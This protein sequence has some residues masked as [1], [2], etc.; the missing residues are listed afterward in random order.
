MAIIHTTSQ[1]LPK[2][3][4]AS[5]ISAKKGVSGTAQQKANMKKTST[6]S[7]STPYAAPFSHAYDAWNT[8]LHS[9]MDSYTKYMKPFTKDGFSTSNYY[10]PFAKEYGEYIEELYKKFNFTPYSFGDSYMMDES[11]CYYAFNVAGYCR[12]HLEV[13]TE[14]GFLVVT[15]E[16]SL[17]KTYK[18]FYNHAPQRYYR[19]YPLPYGCTEDI[20]ASMEKG[21]LYIKIAY[22]LEKPHAL[23]P[24]KT[25]KV[26]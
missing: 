11:F 5:R 2:D 22:S 16:P 23:S 10:I 20:V 1:G 17:S 8:Y 19:K 3:E 24:K 12:E 25:Y 14:D 9:I 6:P 7:S 26:Q 15:A 18:S 13:F 4:T 21:M